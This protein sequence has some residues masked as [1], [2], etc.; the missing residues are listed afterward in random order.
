MVAVT[1]RQRVGQDDRIHRARAGRADRLDVDAAIG[2]QRVDRAPGERAVRAAA[3]Q[4][5]VDRLAFGSLLLRSSHCLI[6][7]CFLLNADYRGCS[8]INADEQSIS[9]EYVSCSI[10]EIALQI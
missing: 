5:E 8:R 3:L 1:L 2:K 9:Y 6:R 10:R 7:T 4:G